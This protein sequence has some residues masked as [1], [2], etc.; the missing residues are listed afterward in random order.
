MKKLLFLSCCLICIATMAQQKPTWVK[1]PDSKFL[2]ELQTASLNIEKKA[3]AKLKPTEL[4]YA[5]LVLTA[6]NAASWTINEY[7]SFL[8][9]ATP[10]IKQLGIV[11]DPDDGGEV[12]QDPDDGGE[13]FASKIQL[14]K[15]IKLLCKVC[16]ACCIKDLGTIK[17]LKN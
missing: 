13:V 4:A 12:F 7:Q 9:K 15:G 8:K 16:T 3:I 10:L 2:N 17:T 11:Q 5:K 6:N 14:Q 1:K